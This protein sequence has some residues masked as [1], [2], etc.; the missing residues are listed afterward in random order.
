M[1]SW[2]SFA[3]LGVLD[4]GIKVVYQELDLVPGLGVAENVFLGHYPHTPRGL[5]DFAEMRQR[6]QACLPSL[7]RRSTSTSQ[8]GNCGWPSSLCG[9]R[10]GTVTANVS[11]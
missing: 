7:V 9:N 5:V 11:S 4:R 3:V 6:T 1:A 8:S 2:S 10:P